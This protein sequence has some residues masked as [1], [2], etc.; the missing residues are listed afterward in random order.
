MQAH[1]V[2]FRIVDRE[3]LL[4]VNFVGVLLRF[5]VRRGLG[6]KQERM[7]YR[8]RL[9]A[10]KSTVSRRQHLRAAPCATH[11]ETLTISAK[12]RQF[13]TTDRTIAAQPWLRRCIFVVLP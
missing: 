4:S 8:N 1:T 9:R 12:R 5:I 6:L 10:L 7:R 2:L 13:Q 11:A 3:A